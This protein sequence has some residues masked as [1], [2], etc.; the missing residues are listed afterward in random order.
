M[1]VY[2]IDTI[3]KFVPVRKCLVFNLS[4]KHQI[5]S[6]WCSLVRSHHQKIEVF[7][8][9]GTKIDQL[10][11]YFNFSSKIAIEYNDQAFQKS[12][13]SSCG[14]F[15]I[16]FLFER[17]LNFDLSFQDLLSEVF[18]SNLEINEKIVHDFCN[19]L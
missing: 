9:L 13:T 7:D 17:L 5:G 14:Y 4:K 1:G 12:T 3:P 18:T 8:S 19:N 6:H 10:T 16:T 2:S 15:A 11:P